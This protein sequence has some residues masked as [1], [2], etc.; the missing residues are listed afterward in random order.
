MD[1]RQQKTRKAIFQAFSSLLAKKHYNKI[2]VQEIIDAANVGRSTFYAHFETKD[3]LLNELCQELFDHIIS[4][5]FDA[6]HTHGL[7]NHNEPESVF[8]HLLQHLAEN[9]MHIL[10]LLSSE[11]S[12]LFLPYFRIRLNDLMKTQFRIQNDE[13]PYDFLINHITGS[14]VEMTLW[15]IQN[16]MEEAPEELD[17]YFRKVIEPIC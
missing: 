12:E 13:I 8:T 10:E 11:S 6:S 3:A 2:T 17:H 7:D 5:A 14:F 9:D 4:S 16:G 1:R 15:W